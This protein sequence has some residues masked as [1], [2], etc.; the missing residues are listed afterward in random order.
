MSLLHLCLRR[1]LKREQAGDICIFNIVTGL[2][3]ASI[4]ICSAGW[5]MEFLSISIS[6]R[7]IKLGVRSMQMHQDILLIG[8]YIKEILMERLLIC[9]LIR[10]DGSLSRYTGSGQQWNETGRIMLKGE[11]KNISICGDGSEII[12][13]TSSAC[14]YRCTYAS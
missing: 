3:R 14:I 13:A 2:F 6:D 1:S 9:F 12:A 10:G 11:I 4:Q 8:G 5:Q 7:L